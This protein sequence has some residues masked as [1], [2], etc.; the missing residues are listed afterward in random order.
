MSILKK[1]W[2][3]FLIII[4]IGGYMWYSK[5]N[6]NQDIFTVTPVNRGDV[7]QV[8]SASATLLA[9]QDIDLN[10]ETAGRVRSITTKVGAQVSQDTSLAMIESASLDGDVKKARAALDKAQADAGVNDDTLR[11]A[12]DA[13][14][15]AKQYV[16]DVADAEDQKVNATDKA[17]DNAVDYA[18]DVESYYNQVVNDSGS[19]S[20]AA[21]SAKLSM[22]SANNATKSAQEAK[23]TARRNRDVAMRVANN[24]YDSQKEKVKSLESKSRLVIENS[25]IT[26]AAANYDI[27]LNNLDKAVLKAPVNGTVTAL[28]YQRGEVIGS[29]SQKSFGKLLSADLILEAKI[30]ESDIASIQLNQMT[31]VA[32]DALKSDEKLNATVIE[33]DLDATLIQDVVYY[34]IKLRLTAIDKRLKSGMSGDVD[35]HITEKKNVLLLPTRAVKQDGSTRYIEVKST[36]GKT[37][38]RKDVKVGLEG[39]DG[40][41]EIV[42][43]IKEGDEIIT[44]KK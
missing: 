4:V 24:S 15:N 20:V 28:N 18:S 13:E 9:D 22:T 27:A 41:I 7:S 30:P 16:N 34:K 23:D 26:I 1:K 12:R 6:A 39:S 42:S 37:A 43:G 2:L 19:G 36:D 8:V 35:I 14:K 33:I 29:A 17:Y 40:L 38:E 32:F 5:R 11:E 44:G 25:A 10:F 21:K 31:T 3:W